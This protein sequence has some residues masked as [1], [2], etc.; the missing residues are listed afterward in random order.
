[1]NCQTP[2]SVSESQCFFYTLSGGTVSD[3]SCL[4]TLTGT[5]LLKTSNQSSPAEVKVLCFYTVKPGELD[6]PS[7]HSDTSSIT[8]HSS[9]V[10]TPS[11][12]DSPFPVST[13]NKASDSFSEMRAQ[14]VLPPT[15]T[16]NPSVITETDSVTLNCQTP[17]SVSMS[18]C[19]FRTVRGGPAKRFS[20][21]QTL[22][23]TELL[24][25]TNQSSPAEV[26][27]TCFYLYVSSSPDSDVSS[28]IVRTSLPPK[29]TVNPPIIT[30]TESVTMNCQTPSSVSES[31]CFFY[32]LSGGT[33]SDSSC[34]KTLTG[35]ELLKMAKQSSPAEVKVLCFY[36]VKLGELDSPSPHSDTSSITIHSSS[37]CTPST[38]DSPFPVSTPNKA[39]DSF[40]E[41]RAQA[42]LP[43]TL[44]VNPSVITETGS[45][46][47]NCQTPS[48][49]SMSE[50]YFRTVRG[51]PAKRFSCLQKLTGTELLKITNQSSPAEVKVTC[52]Y[53]YVSSSPDSDVS[54]IIVRTSL[55]PKLT[56]NP[57]II[58]ETESVTMNCQTPSSVSESQCFF[59]TLS[60][61]TVSDSS[62]LKTLTGTELLK[63]ANQ[64]SPA[65]VKVLCFY[66]VKLGELDSPSPHSDTSSI[67]IHSSS[68]CTPSTKDSPFPVSTPNKASGLTV[69]RP[70]STGSFISTLQTSVKPASETDSGTTPMNPETVNNITGPSVST[71]SNK[72]SSFPGNTP[73]TASEMLK[74]VVVT[75]GCGVSVGIILLVSAILW[76]KRKAGS[77][78]VKKRQLQNK[79]PDTYHLYCTISEEPAASA[80]NAPWPHPVRAVTVLPACKHWFP[81]YFCWPTGLYSI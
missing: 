25:I 8:I 33:V 66:T 50:C 4:K 6:S 77:E 69:G 46:T 27:V 34:L 30:E 53:L 13:P 35:T 78:E 67:T 17:S 49:V 65:E 15:L 73:N 56:V 63:M 32:T 28:I 55:P 42:V 29:L 9:S 76:N 58:T 21:L 19:Y 7:P 60:G 43:P 72:D 1:M 22:T 31:Q 44:T 70:S 20:C 79:D 16:V 64:S 14:A 12:K 71:T 39:S 11:T 80:L 47:L 45:V 52:F 5:E 41:M 23:G 81:G 24:K 57:P 10:R 68:V 2:S 51:G 75:A 36:T 59:Y 61:G 3:S 38:K 48:S 74:L 18:E 62:C 40:S 54:S 26:K 37:V